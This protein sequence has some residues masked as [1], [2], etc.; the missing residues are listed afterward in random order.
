LL[1][2]YSYL[3]C[4]RIPTH[5]RCQARTDVSP[6]RAVEVIVQFGIGPP[7]LYHGGD[8][9]PVVHA[10]GWGRHVNWHPPAVADPPAV[11]TVLKRPNRVAVYRDSGFFTLASLIASARVM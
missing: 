6:Q 3:S 10:Q 2:S 4:V 7:I 1:P 8:H 11:V 5:H 9:R